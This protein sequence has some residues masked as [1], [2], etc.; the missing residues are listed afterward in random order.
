LFKKQ[1]DYIRN[2]KLFVKRVFITDEFI[3]FIPKYLSFVKAMIDAED[4]PLNVS[5]ETLQQ[6]RTLRLIQKHVI[7]KILEMI[8]NISKDDKKYETF[9]KEFGT[10]LKVGAIED[11]LNSQKIVKLLQF[12]SSY[13][14]SNMTSLDEYIGRMKKNQTDIYFVTG[15]SVEEA[16]KSPFLERLIARNYEVLYLTEPID[17]IFV[18]HV[19]MY[20]GKMFQNIAKGNLKFGDEDEQEKEEQEKLKAKFSKLLESIQKTLDDHVEKGQ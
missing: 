14:K 8:G 13:T 7:K 5:R 18:Q 16:E 20:N 2:V 17:E 6:H 15:S 12:H 3:D 10:S 9:M 19:S 11:K 1:D 4:A